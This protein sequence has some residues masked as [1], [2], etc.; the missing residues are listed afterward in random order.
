ML[1]CPRPLQALPSK[2]QPPAED[3]SK[4]ETLPFDQ[5]PIAK[6]Y[7][8]QQQLFKLDSPKIETVVDGKSVE[9]AKIPPGEHEPN[10]SNDVEVVEDLFHATEGTTRMEQMK[11]KARLETTGQE[12]EGEESEIREQKTKLTKK[13]KAERAKQKKLET[14]AKQAAK[15]ATAKAKAKAKKEAAKAAA[16][17][18]KKAKKEKAEAKKKAVEKKPEAK[19]KSRSK[20]QKT[21]QVQEPEVAQEVHEPSPWLE[22]L[23]SQVPKDPSDGEGDGRKSFARRYRPKGSVAG[24]RWD[25]VKYA[26]N[27][28][29]RPLVA[30]VST[31]EAGELE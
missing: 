1:Q 16:L 7:H 26:F 29:V 21:N 10:R 22:A 13:E 24:D 28:H 6:E 27:T 23:P 18:K 15:K 17:E 25:G 9:P 19:A 31:V 20:K 5:S 4:V 14:K 12:G 3:I 8:N 11:E 2:A 30:W